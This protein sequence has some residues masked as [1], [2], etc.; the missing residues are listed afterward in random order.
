M[1]MAAYVVS[2]VTTFTGAGG[3][4]SCSVPTCRAMT[5]RVIFVSISVGLV[6]MRSNGPD[7]LKGDLMVRRSVGD[8]LPL[9][10]SAKENPLA[11]PQREGG[12][13]LSRDHP[14]IRG[15]DVVVPSTKD[16]SLVQLVGRADEAAEAR[17]PGAGNLLLQREQLA[18]QCPFVVH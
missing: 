2:D 9:I 1:A 3:R 17:R 11:L 18:A 6:F 15:L 10:L 13:E 4:A 14:E 8:S 7:S 16:E 12:D 5:S